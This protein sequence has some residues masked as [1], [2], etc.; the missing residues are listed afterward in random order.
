[1]NKTK[2]VLATIV[3]LFATEAGAATKNIWMSNAEIMA[4]PTGTDGAWLN[5]QRAADSSWG[6]PDLKDQNKTHA[7]YCVA[8]GLVYS[9]TGDAALRI[10]TRDGLM[11][12]KRTLDETAE[13]ESASNI[14]GSFRQIS[15]YVIAADLI[16]LEA[17]APDSHTVFTAWLTT[18]KT[19]ELQ[20]SN[21]LFGKSLKRSHESTAQWGLGS[22]TAMIAIARYL[23]DSAGV[24]RCDSFFRAYGDQSYF[25]SGSV[26]FYPSATGGDYYIRNGGYEASWICSDTASWVAI[27]P[28]CV[29][30][31]AGDN[32][33]TDSDPTIESADIDGAI[34]TEISRAVS[35]GVPTPFVWPPCTAGKMY[36]WSN[37][38]YLF[39]QAELLYKA[40][41]TGAYSY[42]GSMMKRMMDFNVR[43][44]NESPQFSSMRWMSWLINY[45]YGTSYITYPLGNTGVSV[46]WGMSWTDWT[47]AAAPCPEPLP[48]I[49]DGG[50]P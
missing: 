18:M 32:V 42:N 38:N 9:R 47:H 49:Q 14:L 25:P 17:F 30:I 12:A 11:A 46:G 3:L 22:G 34:A 13:F 26:W 8:G 1:M 37:M 44:G 4:L 33:C 10:K 23:G 2:A 43:A 21:P 28:S 20:N 45:R 36:Q 16:D 41:Y 48:L 19:Q 35:G 7:A 31:E 39:I 50:V 6:T 29:K 15:A 5:V 40:G 27:S 24:A